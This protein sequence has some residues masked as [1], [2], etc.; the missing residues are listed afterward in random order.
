MF[1]EFPLEALACRQIPA[2]TCTPKSQLLVGISRGILAYTRLA[3]HLRPPQSTV[4]C[5]HR[6]PFRG[7]SSLARLRLPRR[8]SSFGPMRCP[9][10]T[11]PLIH[12][13]LAKLLLTSTWAFSDVSRII[14][15]TPPDM[16]GRRLIVNDHQFVFGQT[17]LLSLGSLVVDPSSCSL[18]SSVTS[19]MDSSS[20]GL[21]P[22]AHTARKSRCS[23]CSHLLASLVVEQNVR[24]RDHRLDDHPD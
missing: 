5:V 15:R 10:L 9:S 23:C 21:A 22:S 17:V 24:P 3:T 1:S 4:Y 13:R 14:H 12:L 11:S 19:S 7:S 18:L 20:I 8:R 16:P 6:R 2:P